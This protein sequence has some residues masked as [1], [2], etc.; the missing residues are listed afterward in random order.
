MIVFAAGNKYQALT[1]NEVNGIWYIFGRRMVKS[2]GKLTR[3]AQNYNV[4]PIEPVEVKEIESSIPEV[5]PMDDFN[6]VGSKHH[7]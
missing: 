6:Y 5:N 1:I 4:G 3:T 2:S 7:Y